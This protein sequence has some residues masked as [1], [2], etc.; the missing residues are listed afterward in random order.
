MI[1]KRSSTDD[2]KSYAIKTLGMKTLR[3]NAFENF[4]NGL[5]TFE[6]VLRATTED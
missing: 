5:T 3:D 4:A 2:I 1:M 6:E